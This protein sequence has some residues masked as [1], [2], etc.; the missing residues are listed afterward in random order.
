MEILIQI[1]Q[2]LVDML[3]LAY[4]KGETAY[5]L[6][7]EHFSSI[8]SFVTYQWNSLFLMLSMI[9]FW[10]M[11]VYI[12]VTLTTASAWIFWIFASLLLGLIQMIYVS[13]QFVMIANDVMI[14][15]CLKTYQVIMR[16]RTTQ[17]LFFFSNTLRKKRIRTSRRRKWRCECELAKSYSE[18]LQVQVM[19]PKEPELEKPP[20]GVNK[21]MKRRTH[22]FATMQTLYEEQDGI[23]N[24]GA[25]SPR[26]RAHE[27]KRMSSFSRALLDFDN[28][29]TTPNMDPT[30]AQDLGEMTTELL[31]STLILKR[32]HLTLED[33]VVNNARAVAFSGQYGFSAASRRQIGAYYNEV[34]KG[35]EF[36]AEAPVSADEPLAILSDRISLVR[37]MKQNM[38]RTALMLSG[39]GAQ[40][41]YHLGTLR[42][43]IDA[44]LYDDIKVISGTSGGSITSACCAMYSTKEIF[45]KICVPTVS[46]DFK[47]NGEMKQKNIKWFPPIQDMVAYWLKKR[48][49]VDSEYFYRTCEFY[50]GA[51]T[52]AEAFERTGKHV[53][54]TVSASRASGG[55]A[56]RLLLNHISTPHV[57][58]ASAVAASCALPGVM[59]PAKLQT[60]SSLGEIEPFEVDGVEWID[61]SVQA[62]LPFQRI[63][64]LF[65]V[66]NFIVCQTNF[67]VQP[68]LNKDHHPSTRSA[69]WKLFQLFEWDIRSRALKLGKLGLFPKIFGQ[70]I[71]KVFKQKYHGNLTLVPRFTAAQTFGLKALVNPSVKEME[72]YLKYGQVAVWPYVSV[73]RDMIRLEKSLDECLDNL[74]VRCSK[75]HVEIDM[76]DTDDLDSIASSSASLNAIS[77]RRSSVRFGHHSEIERLKKKLSQVGR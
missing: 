48:L 56:Q 36:L 19:E 39:G 30:V 31:Q 32:N 5:N 41:I 35:L 46:T 2:W 64:T 16:S 29:D 47:L 24:Q 59:K 26:R 55:T 28:E 45:E 6:L 52:F 21:P 57:T 37:K 62:D 12:A 23:T 13:Y 1:P 73:I 25:E 20:T 58:L 43:L 27:M 50:Y 11:W 69:Y 70:D 44:D 17:L 65:N 33:L 51:T 71:S 77:L 34:S 66:S 60:K 4:S 67:H 63:S 54:I 14:L 3:E 40:A 15:T 38:G 22:S 75:L 42:A 18:F 68:F 7:L 49:L 8:W 9:F 10:P 74:K 61:G 72:G 53:C 76:S